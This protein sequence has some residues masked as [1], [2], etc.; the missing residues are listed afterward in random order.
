MTS[1]SMASEEEEGTAFMLGHWL[2]GFEVMGNKQT[3]TGHHVM[4]E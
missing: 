1:G 4:E 3:N 2:E